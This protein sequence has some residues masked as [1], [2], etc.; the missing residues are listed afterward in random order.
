[1]KD[2]NLL[3]DLSLDEV[4]VPVR[5]DTQVMF[6]TLS[7]R[8]CRSFRQCLLSV[9]RGNDSFGWISKA[10]AHVRFSNKTESINLQIILSQFRTAYQTKLQLSS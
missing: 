4:V 2:V 5:S 3:C 9:L 6:P 7:L 1:M 8:S 10:P